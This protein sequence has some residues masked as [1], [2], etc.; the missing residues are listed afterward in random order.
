MAVFDMARYH[1]DTWEIPVVVTDDATPPAPIILT[2]STIVF[3]LETMS[4]TITDFYFSDPVNPAIANTAGISIGRND[5]GGEFTFTLTS[6]L[7]ATLT[8]RTQY[9][10][11]VTV[12]SATG[13]T[14]TYFVATYSIKEKALH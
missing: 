5:L 14:L 13:V 8:T 2:G 3:S 1:G 11:D 7:M 12:V 10:W 6:A 9:T 4:E